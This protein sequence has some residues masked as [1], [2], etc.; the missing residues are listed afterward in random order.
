MTNQLTIEHIISGCKEG[1]AKC[2]QELV[3]RFSGLLYSVCLRYMGDATK[4]QDVLQDSFI[5]IFK[6]IDT[7]DSDKGSLQAWMRKITVNV[8]L[9]SLNKKSLN[10]TPLSVD[11][12]DKVS[13]APDAISNMSA[14][15]LMDVIRTLPEGYRQVFNL[16]VIEG[17]NHREIGEQL[18]IAEVTSRSNLS[19]AKQILRKKL[20]KYQTNESWAK[21]N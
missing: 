13:V 5:R 21:I 2:Q 8:A 18:G 15:S 7:F 3:H 11:Y 10:T 19:R 1:H 6:Y 16:S 4:S 14:E 17:Y 12:N 20:N 9:K